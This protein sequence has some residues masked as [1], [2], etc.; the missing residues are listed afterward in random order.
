MRARKA[1]G[2]WPKTAKDTSWPI[3]SCGDTAVDGWSWPSFWANSAPSSLR[4]CSWC[5]ASTCLRPPCT[6]RAAPRPPGR[7]GA[8]RPTP[9]CPRTSPRSCLSVRSG[10]EP[11]IK[12]RQRS[13][14]PTRDLPGSSRFVLRR[15]AAQCRPSTCTPQQGSEGAPPSV[16][17]ATPRPDGVPQPAPRYHMRRLFVSGW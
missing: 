11:P 10:S 16:L 8:C 12:T 1:S 13:R 15:R 5:R 6:P 3:H 2:R 17:S 14:P 4:R 9:G 7:L